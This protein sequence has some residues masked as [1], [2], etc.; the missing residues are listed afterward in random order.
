MG[1]TSSKAEPEEGK[2]DELKSPQE[3]SDGTP[4]RPQPVGVGSD[5][6]PVSGPVEISL[7]S[8]DAD[9]EKTQELPD[10]VVQAIETHLSERTQEA[11]TPTKSP[12]KPKMKIREVPIVQQT[13]PSDN[14]DVIIAPP[15]KKPPR[16]A[17]RIP[18]IPRVQKESEEKKAPS[19]EMVPPKKAAK[20]SEVKAKE[21]KESAGKMAAPP[22]PAKPS[23]D[24]KA[25]KGSAEKVPPPEKEKK[26]LIEKVVPPSKEKRA[27]TEKMVPPAKEKKETVEKAVPPSKEKKGSA[28]KIVPLAKEKKGSAE[29][30]VPT[31]K[32]KK[33]SNEKI[34]P[35]SN[36]KKGGSAE[37]ISALTKS[38]SSTDKVPTNPVA[39]KTSSSDSV[40]QDKKKE[41]SAIKA[42]AAPKQKSQMKPPK[43]EIKTGQ[44][45]EQQMMCLEK[46]HY[47]SIAT[48]PT[49]TSFSKQTV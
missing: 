33:G 43:F 6:S 47:H 48:L 12:K 46:A 38:S 28:E 37:K 26:G 17:S 23:V 45:E 25:K 18:T 44:Q 41:K 4:A 21:K 10:M 35:L 24:S 16:I 31:S 34:V 29:K 8:P 9:L 13:E 3:K 30:V 7:R 36:E 5:S 2:S 42:V 40:Q 1:G 20:E 22:P 14:G 27:S 32:D 19:K 15:V 11:P 39:G 49:Y